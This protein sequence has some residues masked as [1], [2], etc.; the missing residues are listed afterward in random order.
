MSWMG[1]HYTEESQQALRA[2]EYIHCRQCEYKARLQFDH[3][4]WSDHRCGR[5]GL[6]FPASKINE[7]KWYHD[8]RQK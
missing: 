6:N 2:L 7:I 5:C 3:K 8:I 4:M 1:T